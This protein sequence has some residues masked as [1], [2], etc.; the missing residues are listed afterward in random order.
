MPIIIGVVV[1]GVALLV[2]AFVAF[3]LLKKRKNKRAE[4]PESEDS[5]HYA[6]MSQSHSVYSAIN[7]VR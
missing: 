5:T 7:A 3:F 6:E 2:G 1:G 4:L